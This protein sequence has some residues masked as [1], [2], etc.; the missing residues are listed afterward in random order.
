M[1]RR[2]GAWIKLELVY[3]PFANVFSSYTHFSISLGPID[4][5]N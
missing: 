2:G 4:R 3:F 1:W 5:K